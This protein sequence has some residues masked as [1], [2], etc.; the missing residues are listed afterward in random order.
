[1]RNKDSH[2]EILRKLQQREIRF[3]KDD[4]PLIF[5]KS[6]KLRQK[7]IRHAAEEKKV[8][9]EEKKSSLRTQMHKIIVL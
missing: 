2:D 7:P 5:N 1:M 9:P 3:G 8:Q 6:E 4:I